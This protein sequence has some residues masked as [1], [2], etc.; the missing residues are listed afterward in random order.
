MLD[1]KDNCL[2]LVSPSSGGGGGGPESSVKEE[3]SVKID[4]EHQSRRFKR[5]RNNQATA[6]RHSMDDKKLHR[7]CL[8]HINVPHSENVSP[9]SKPA[10]I[11]LS[12]KH[13]LEQ[14]EEVLSLKEFLDKKKLSMDMFA[15]KKPKVNAKIQLDPWGNPY[16]PS[17]LPASK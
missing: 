10:N 12:I 2:K 1:K 7:I 14:N 16:K 8:D 13:P 4:N 3:N 11:D 5:S 17:N 15:V 6:L 9:D